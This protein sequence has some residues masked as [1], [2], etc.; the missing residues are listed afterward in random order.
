MEKEIVVSTKSGISFTAALTIAFIILKLCGV[1]SWSWVW[2]VSPIWITFCL[3]TIIVGIWAICYYFIITRYNKKM[4]ST[5]RETPKEEP[6]VQE[7]EVKEEVKPK[8]SRKNGTK[9]TT[10]KNGGNT[11]TVQ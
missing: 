8:R 2:V 6:K 5:I 11:E 3:S 10:K 4:E 1:I 7:P 9:R